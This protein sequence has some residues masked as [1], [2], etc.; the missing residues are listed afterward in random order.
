MVMVERCRNLRFRNV[1]KG[2][3]RCATLLPNVAGIHHGDPAQGEGLAA[4]LPRGDPEPMD[5]P[6]IVRQPQQ[7]DIQDL[8]RELADRFHRYP[9]KMWSE[10]TLIALISILDC[11]IKFGGDGLK[12]PDT[13]PLRIVR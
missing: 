1:P 12:L 4:I 13:I 7:A 10:S 3:T 5:R 11:Q 2:Q 8:R 6:R 9:P